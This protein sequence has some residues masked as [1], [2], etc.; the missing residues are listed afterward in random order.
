ML[1]TA[2]ALAVALAAGA[3]THGGSALATDPDVGDGP[4]QLLDWAQSE[5]ERPD[6]RVTV[7]VL[8]DP[9]VAD[10]EAA[11]GRAVTE[12][13]GR[14][15]GRVPGQLVQA[16]V[17]ADALDA[18]RASPGVGSVRRPLP[19]DL[20]LAGGLE[21]RVQAITGEELAQI[22]ATAWHAA[23]HTGAGV[24]IGIV[25]G[26]DG[27][28]WATA[29]GA[30]E[31][32]PIDPAR[33][34][35]RI[36][37]ATCDVWDSGVAHGV[38]VAEIVHEVAPDAQLYLAT[39]LTASDLLAAVDWFAANGVTIVNRSLGAALDGPGDGTGPLDTVA[40]HAV[41]AGIAW[42]NSVGNAAGRE[43]RRGDYYRAPFTDTDGDGWHEFVNPYGPAAPGG[44]H[45]DLAMRCTGTVLSS[46]RWSDWADAAAA[47][48]YDLFVFSTRDPGRYHAAFDTAAAL[49]HPQLV[50]AGYDDQGA[51]A[52]PL[53]HLLDQCTGSTVYLAIRMAEANGGT[54]GDTLELM[55]EDDVEAWSDPYSAGYPVSDSANPGVFAIG[56]VDDDHTIAY[57]SSEGPTNDGRV[58]PDF[59]AR[60]GVHTSVPGLTSFHGT[61]ASSPAAAGLAA[62]VQSAGRAGSPLELREWLLANAATDRGPC[63]PDQQFGYGELTLPDPTAADGAPGNPG[64]GCAARFATLAPT[65]LFDSREGE[66]GPGPKGKLAADATVTLT[67]AGTGAVPA[68]ATAVVLNATITEPDAAGYVT[69]YPTGQPR[70]LASAVNVIAPGQT[71]AALVT[72][73]LGDGGAVTLYTKS[74]AHLVV[75]LAG[76]YVAVDPAGAADGRF[77]ALTP[78][79]LYDSR[80]GEPGPGPKGRV[81]ARE[82]V[83]VPVLG[84]AGVPSSGVAAVV[85]NVTGTDANGPGYV[86]AFPSG[87]GIPLASTLNLAAA[88]STAAN[89]AIVP[90]GTGGQISVYASHGA[91]VVA[92]VV[93]YITDASAPIAATGLFVPVAPARVFDTRRDGVP[94]PADGT[95]SAQIAGVAGVPADA[96]AVAL[97]VTGA[98]SPL[99]YLTVWDSGVS[100]PL[101]STLNLEHAPLDT[102]ANAAMLRLG[103]NG[104]IDVYSK[105]GGDVLADVTGYFLR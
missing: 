64:V 52:P 98:D 34:F 89:L 78:Q 68:E 31:L 54:V 59:T 41:A 40:D 4:D 45:E 84:R 38:A 60:S 17:P 5:A 56:A 55:A 63:G 76:Y 95:I 43:G 22:N 33:T 77:V 18:L 6:T 92:D 82:V 66:P 15:T 46:L 37:G 7:E 8:P 23:G 9:R 61:S 102:R 11:I 29:V 44:P 86:T 80:P 1:A 62:L 16:A 32:P 28:L 53:E 24:R 72:V 70:P 13:G 75:D 71:R 20:T 91:H 50:T 85:V 27:S 35:C 51:G 42:F 25:D 47:T 74:A 14:V 101:A 87:G 48:D 65:R 21:P 67:V 97:T 57:Y 2:L 88:G 93:G 10:A 100:R 83:D 12:L 36:A 99:G 30:G 26:F 69:A 103:A 49:A 79:R 94:V 39:A 81:A 3:G 90:L 105:S 96:G 19:Q 104:R 58:K 73:P